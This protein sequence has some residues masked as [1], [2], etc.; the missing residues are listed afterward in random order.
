MDNQNEKIFKCKIDSNFH[1][2]KLFLT[3]KQINIEISSTSANNNENRNYFNSYTLS[4]F[5]EI[6]SYFKLFK[7]IVE[8]YNNILKLLSKKK[9]YITEN[10]DK[11]LFFTLKIKINNKTRKINLTLSKESNKFIYNQKKTMNENYMDNFNYELSNIKNKITN[12]EQN[13]YL[14][15][16]SNN[17]IPTN[18]FSDISNNEYP[19]LETIISKL[20]KLE[21]ENNE[22]NKRIKMLEKQ[23]IMY[24]NQNNIDEE[25]EEEEINDK[26][27]N[28][29]FNKININ[30]NSM[31]NNKK[32]KI[33]RHNSFDKYN[34]ITSNFEPKNSNL[35]AY[36]N[37][38]IPKDNSMDTKYKK[39]KTAMNNN[40]LRNLRNNN[41][42][43]NL[44]ME[45]Q[46]ENDYEKMKTYIPNSKAYKYLNSLPSTKRENIPNINSKIIFNNNELKFINKKLSHGYKDIQVKL[47]LLYRA[48]SDGDFET[49]LKFK[50]QNKLKTLTLFHTMEG[51]RFGF[52]IEKRIKTT[53]KSG[54]KILEVPGSS[55][56]IGLNNLV[57]Y[58][59]Y[60]KKDSLFYK[61]DNLLCFGYC[62]SVNNN[63]TRWL[64]Y[65]SRNNFRY[66]KFLFGDQNDVYLNLDTSKIIGNNLYYHIK[67]VEVF[68]VNLE[69]I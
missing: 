34:S 35:I 24:E 39:V 45:D 43:P 15:S 2:I 26:Y 4:H 46:F 67:D 10:E 57:Y 59:V 23:I 37:S 42:N 9:F 36:N 65:T 12:L 8:V 63:K 52:Y 54:S 47:K 13:P 29:D 11:T 32:S 7:S 19:Q 62:S 5:Q 16:Y 60:M 66:K 30:K 1:F 25:E 3:Q 58:N 41:I 69:G 17:Y 50:C 48:S 61:N 31:I 18:K 14:Y 22:K 55:F 44:T 6:N 53:L 21:N 27:N 56:I 51:A 38:Y 33:R 28:N 40:H 64:V 68:E 49:A 20:N